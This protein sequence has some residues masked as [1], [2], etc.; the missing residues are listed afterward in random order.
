MGAIKDVVD[1]ATQLSESVQD[2]RFT[3]D[4]FKIIQ[5]VNT[6][7]SEQASLTEKNIELMSENADL[8]Q[9][10]SVFK[11]DIAILNQ[12]ISNLKNQA[13]DIPLDIPRNAHSLLSLK[14]KTPFYY[15]DGDPTPF[16]PTCWEVNKKQIHF[17]SPLSSG[18]GPE[19]TCPNCKNIIIHPRNEYRESKGISA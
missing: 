11:S 8:K 10:I 17:P 16:C 18:V 13:G 15:A 3:S 12:Q 2:R 9:S 6:I 1:L 5:L 19:Y 7:Q 4:L 14:F